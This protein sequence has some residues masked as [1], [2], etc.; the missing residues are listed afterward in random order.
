MRTSIQTRQEALMKSAV[1]GLVL[2]GSMLASGAALGRP[3][4][5][6][7]SAVLAPP[8][9]GISYVRFGYQAATN[10]RYALVVGERADTDPETTTYDALLYARDSGNAWRYVRILASGGWNENDDTVHPVDIG[11]KGDLASAE[12]SNTG[13]KIF[14]FDGSDWVPAGS[15]T[16]PSE[17]VAIEG[18]SILYGGSDGWNGQVF[19]PNGSGGWKVTRLQGQPRDGDDEFWGG[20]VD[21]R[22]G[23]A[24]LGTPNTSFMDEPQE[25]PIYQRAADGSWP[26]LTKLQV[27]AGQ[28]GLGAEVALHLNRAIVDGLSGA[29][30][31][32]DVFGEPDDRIQAV[33]QYAIGANIY[34]MDEDIDLLAANSWD[35]DLNAEV[36]NVFQPDANGKYQHVA[37]LKAKNGQTLTTSFEIQGNTVV[38]GGTGKAYVFMLPTSY[39]AP[40]PKYE[41]FESGNGANWTPRAGSQFAVVRPT[42][43]N[44]VYR[45]TSTVGDAQSVLGNTSWTNQAIEADVRPTAFRCADCWVGVA[46]RYQDDRNY[47]YVTLRN[48]GTVQ[49]KRMLNGTFR[50][51]G[52]APVAVGLDRTY[53]LR[54]ESVGTS[55]R[56]Y[57]DGVLALSIDDPATNS[58]GKA[59]LV[60]YGASADYDNVNVTP[61]PRATIY[62]DDFTPS[63]YSDVI[64][65]DFLYTGAGQW[66]PANGTLAQTSVA[67][68]A[69]A[70]IGTPT[71]DQVVAMRITPKSYAAGTATQERWTGLIARYTDDRNYYYVTLRSSNKISLRKLVNG[72]ITELATAALTVT[73]GTTY[74]VRLDATGQSLRVWVNGALVLQ[75]ADSSHAKGRGGAV[76]YKAAAQFDDYV[77][78]QP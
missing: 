34:E 57:V 44:G 66:A 61:T 78:Y 35:P 75:A 56:V 28:R 24:I 72:A 12:M 20:P 15:G 10:G 33:N 9:N 30:V 77:A 25:I 32:S 38:A 64:R 36:V 41:T 63:P 21:L 47:Y 39:G 22:F 67:G 2:G 60:M 7:E 45:Q 52:S 69:R 59:A 43:L 53:R 3:V 46:T 6:E 13:T 49:L 50:T 76:T 62:A 14:R 73:P 54:L 19:E 4:Y 65:G 68:D 16:N 71:D 18:D 31:W 48:S 23:R 42:P 40:Q 70:L 55:H 74:A 5:I 8:N 51:L 26:L 17:D 58:P 1:L 29:Y 11:M 27:P 37:L